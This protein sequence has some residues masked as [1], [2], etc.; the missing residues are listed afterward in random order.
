M[1]KKT[2]TEWSLR[3][4]AAES[5]FDFDNSRTSSQCSDRWSLKTREHLRVSE[6]EGI[7]DG[8]LADVVWA[9]EHTEPTREGA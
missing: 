4:L 6:V 9:N 3:T 7:A 1:A 2:L 8:G 5:K